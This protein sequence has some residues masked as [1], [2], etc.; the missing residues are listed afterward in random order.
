[1]VKAKCLAAV[2][3]R[4]TINVRKDIEDTLRMLRLNRA[5]H[6]TIIPSTPQYLGMLQKAKDHITW[7]EISQEILT[8]LIKKRGRLVGG[9]NITLDFL[10]KKGFQSFE[11]LANKIYSSDLKLKDLKDVKPIFR[12]HPPSKGF[13]KS[14]KRAFKDGG[15]TGYRGDKINELIKRMM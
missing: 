5:N 10:K 13:E 7:G 8:H 11:E 2:R 4:G 12:L 15:E 6:A 14:L 9:K 3:V 1:M